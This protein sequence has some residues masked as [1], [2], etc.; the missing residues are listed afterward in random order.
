MDTKVKSELTCSSVQIKSA[1]IYRKFILW[2]KSYRF[3]SGIEWTTSAW[4]L[5]RKEKRLFLDVSRDSRTAS[6]GPTSLMPEKLVLASWSLNVS[7]YLTFSYQPAGNDAWL[8]PASKKQFQ[9]CIS[10]CR[11]GARSFK[12][13]H[14]WQITVL[15]KEL[16]WIFFEMQMQ[17]LKC[18]LIR[19]NS[20][21]HMMYEI[22]ENEPF[23][24]TAK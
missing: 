11:S 22:I 9:V 2:K 12:N 13:I 3:N 14:Y 8:D 21:Y 6:P 20:F 4:K 18:L 17:P 23:W 5:A 16:K 7:L 15:S 1:Q 24:R 19:L 10:I